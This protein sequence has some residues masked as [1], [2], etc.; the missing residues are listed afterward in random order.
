M[1]RSQDLTNQ[2]FNLLTVIKLH[3]IQT[4]LRNNKKVGSRYYWLCKCECGN[5]TIV[6]TTNLKN[7][8]VKSC[9]CLKHLS[10]NFTHKLSRSRLYT[11]Y[12]NMKA[13]C[14][15]PNEPSYKNYGKRGIKI[16]S[17]W[18]EDFSNFYDWAIT[19]GYQENLTIDR[20]DVNGNY[21]PS[22]C[23]WATYKQQSNNTRRNHFI[24]FENE[25]HTI[26]EWA[27]IY[28]IS[29]SLLGERL[30]YGWD[31]QKAV[32]TSPDIYKNRPTKLIKYQGEYHT[33]KEWLDILKIHPTTFYRR[34]KATS[35][36]NCNNDIR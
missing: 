6:H 26:A 29:S 16:C 4:I 31:F 14:Y 21:E 7:G 27:K 36:L 24:T 13:R 12:Y 34:L 28:N 5:T 8:S 3:H 19:H 11:I 2:K 18:L 10:R 17:H 32:S 1:A 9:G 23:R 22:N 30:K 20:I 15:N 25:T 33:K 35:L